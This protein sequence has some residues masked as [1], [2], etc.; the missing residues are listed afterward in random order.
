MIRIAREAEESRETVLQAPVTTPV[1]R[2]DQTRAAREPNL[3][4]T[5]PEK[6]GS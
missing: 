4:W 5:A 2:L 6:P 3:R 1:G